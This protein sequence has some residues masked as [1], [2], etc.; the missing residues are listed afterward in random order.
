MTIAPRAPVEQPFAVVQRWQRGEAGATPGHAPVASGLVE[1]RHPVQRS[2]GEEASNTAVASGLVEREPL[3]PGAG[4]AAPGNAA[5]AS[6]LVER[7]LPV[8]RSPGVEARDSRAVSGLVDPR[9]ELAGAHLATRSGQPSSP[10]GDSEHLPRKAVSSRA[11]A[12]LQMAARAIAAVKAVIPHAGNQKAGLRATRM[13]SF[14]RMLATRDDRCWEYANEETRQLAQ[15]YPEADEAAKAELA[16]GG[17]CGELSWV[18]YHHLRLHARG[19]HLQQASSNN[20]DFMLIGDMATEPGSDLV[21]CDPWPNSPTACLWEDHFAYT[22]DRTK[23]EIHD[24][25]VADGKSFKAAIAAGLRL[26]EYGQQQVERAQLKRQTEE[27]IARGEA[28][29]AG[30]PWVEDVHDTTADGRKFAYTQRDEPSRD[31]GDDAEDDHDHAPGY[32]A[33]LGPCLSW[34]FRL[35]RGAAAQ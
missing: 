20:H 26:T 3:R 10:P 9:P 13:N 32:I 15:S 21:A 5:V 19:E 12:R 4:D 23:I 30:E 22:P 11:Y 7:G 29:W 31:H 33:G 6:G 1:Q 8:Q 14:Y 25:M 16:R 2:G 35:G 27:A 28:G 24:H 34:L 17:N 18:S